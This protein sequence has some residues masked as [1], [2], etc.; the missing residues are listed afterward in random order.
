MT[1]ALG[2]AIVAT[3]LVLRLRALG[4]LVARWRALAPREW[5]ETVRPARRAWPFNWLTLG[6]R[7][8]PHVHLWSMSTPEWIVRDRVARR[9]WRIVRACGWVMLIGVIVGLSPLM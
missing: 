3:A 7:L 8:D 9:E 5:R 1:V 4:R 2:F 6:R